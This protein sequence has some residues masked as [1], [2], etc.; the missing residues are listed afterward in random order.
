MHA[1]AKDPRLGAAGA[2]MGRTAVALR[3]KFTPE[4]ID[5]V[6]RTIAKGA[7]D[8]E[9]ALFIYQ[10][11]RT[12]LDPFARQIYCLQRSTMNPET[13]KYENA[14]VTQVGIDGF[15]LIAE[16]TGEYRGQVVPLFADPSGNWRDF[17]PD[18]LKPPVAA[19]VGVLREGFSEP[20][21]AVANY[22]EF[23]QNTKAGVPN[24]MW[25]EKPSNQLAKCA[26]ALA[27]RKAFPQELSGLYT[28]DEMP[29]EPAADDLPSSPVT[30]APERAG[31]DV[32]TAKVAD[33]GDVELTFGEHR[34]K[35]IRQVPTSYLL[36]NFREPWKDQDKR[37]LAEQRV[38]VGFVRYVYSELLRRNVPDDMTPQ[39]AKLIEREA[40]GEVLQGDEAEDVRQWHLDHPAP[41]AEA[42]APEPAPPAE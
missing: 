5:L 41:A 30:R 1:P 2:S 35:K 26:E 3:Q 10:C 19:K 8:D 37:R 36:L 7:S 33:D 17:W 6:K 11:E 22:K 28:E 38:G 21:Y 42:K 20:L 16:R 23:V 9:L 31:S 12:G 32:M 15:R 24:K 27:L 18:P 25:R 40:A 29:G 39:M 34:G 14:M 13:N 4:Q